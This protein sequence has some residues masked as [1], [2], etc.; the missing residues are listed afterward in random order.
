MRIIT[1]LLLTTLVTL[2]SSPRTHAETAQEQL[3]PSGDLNVILVSNVPTRQPVGTTVTWTATAT[4]TPPYTY[5]LSVARVGE[6]PRVMYDYSSKNEFDWTPVDEGRYLISASVRDSA[7]AIAHASRLFTV[8][9]RAISRP[10]V[11]TTGHPLVALYSAPSC[12][13]GDMR[14]IFKPLNGSRITFTPL[15]PCVPDRTVNFYIGGMRADTTYLMVHEVIDNGGRAERGPLRLFRTGSLPFEFPVSVALDPPDAETSI[16]DGVLLQS[17]VI[18]APDVPPFPFATDLA[19]RVIWYEGT[20]MQSGEVTSLY[21]PV[22]GGTFLLAVDQNDLEGQILR[23]IDLAGHTVRETTAQRV[24]EQL[25]SIGQ[26]P[27]G[28]F[29]HEARRLPNGHTAVIGS[30]ERIM[31]DVQGEGPVHIL[32]DNIVVLDENWQLAWAWNAFDHLDVTREATL[33]ETCE[34]QGPG[35]PP[36]FLG[37]L[38]N[39]WT[40]SNAIAYSPADGNLLLSMRHQD[41]TIKIDYRDGQGNGGVVWRLGPDGDFDISSDDPFPW[42]SH[43]HDPNYISNNQI[44]IYDNGNLRCEDAPSSCFSRGQ[45]YD[46]DESA[47]TASLSLNADLAVYAYA[48]GSAQSLRNGNFHFLSGLS[49]LPTFSASEELRPDGARSYMLTVNSASYRSFRLRDL[50]TPPPDGMP[51]LPD[52]P[53]PSQ[54]LFQE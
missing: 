10:V 26:D 32:A 22:E 1:L 3:Q 12:A 30:V 2:F 31:E 36:L 18:G 42:F 15:K 43:Q 46:L 21:R 49:A 20:R 27:L 7:G 19:G 11:T 23:E 5:R 48:V 17:P 13:S 33:G 39:D 14:V 4:G 28:A 54:D 50:Y 9:A 35:C 16:I 45:V 44:V 52:S 6:S 51:D 25:T 37:E 24:N 8:R 34:H 41:W 53:L 29:H 38:A 40:H 47:M